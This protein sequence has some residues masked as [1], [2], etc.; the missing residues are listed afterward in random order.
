[1]S[2]YEST[3]YD[4]VSYEE[5]HQ[6]ILEYADISVRKIVEGVRNQYIKE[7]VIGHEEIK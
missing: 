1:M 7:G 4:V 3:C 6:F 5:L 2:L